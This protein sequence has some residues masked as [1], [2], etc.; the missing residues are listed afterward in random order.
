MIQCDFFF[1]KMYSLNYYRLRLIGLCESCAVVRTSKLN[2]AKNIDSNG[3]D[4]ADNF[5]K[6]LIS[7][8]SM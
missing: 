1:I 6:L 4:A 3:N 2:H 8:I 7:D 5:S